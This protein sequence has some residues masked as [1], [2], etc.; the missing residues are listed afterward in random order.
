MS[1]TMNVIP[2]DFGGSGPSDTPEA[3]ILQCLCLLQA[4]ADTLISIHVCTVFPNPGADRDNYAAD[5][6]EKLIK[7]A[8][9]YVRHLPSQFQ[10][11]P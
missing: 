1:D 10:P 2:I 7:N 8:V 5:L 11:R 6:R 4:A 9:H 3:L